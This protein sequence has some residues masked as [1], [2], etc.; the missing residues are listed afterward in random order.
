MI[1]F[2][3]GHAKLK[4]NR[5]HMRRG[6]H[7]TPAGHRPGH[8]PPEV[9]EVMIQAAEEAGFPAALDALFTAERVIAEPGAQWMA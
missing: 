8:G 9:V 2:A 4:G 6:G 5:R 1:L 7:R 3:K